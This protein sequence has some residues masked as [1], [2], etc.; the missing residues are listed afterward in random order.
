MHSFKHSSKGVEAGGLQALD[1]PG[2]HNKT[3]SE[4]KFNKSS[5][6]L[7]LGPNK[8]YYH[9]IFSLHYLATLTHFLSLPLRRHNSY[10]S[11]VWHSAF[12]SS[13]RSVCLSHFG[14]IPML[15]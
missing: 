1:Q 6:H 10:L 7:I 15:Q 5:I 11:Q 9:K 13:D 4:K 8:Q 12:L 14:D 3:V 2:L